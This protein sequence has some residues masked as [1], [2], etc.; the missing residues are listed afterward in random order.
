MASFLLLLL[1]VIII[2]IFGL[3][4]TCFTVPG[5]YLNK[6]CRNKRQMPVK[7]SDSLSTVGSV[8][9]QNTKSTYCTFDAE[10]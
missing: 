4:I 9:S 2:A 7:R 1:A 3:F 10:R 8:D 5:C 6:W